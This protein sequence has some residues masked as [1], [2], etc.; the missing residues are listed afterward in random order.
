MLLTI[1]L[2]DGGLLR[3]LQCLQEHVGPV[4][5]TRNSGEN[6]LVAHASVLQC[7]HGFGRVCTRLGQSVSRLAQ[8]LNALRAP[9]AVIIV[10]CGRLADK[11]VLAE[12]NQAVARVRCYDAGGVVLEGVLELPLVDVPP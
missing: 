4:S 8:E 11:A 9:A 12:D 1:K 2:R 7:D 6:G 5:R 3:E 10:R